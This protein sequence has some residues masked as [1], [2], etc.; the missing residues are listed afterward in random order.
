MAKLVLFKRLDEDP[1]VVDV[2]NESA[3]Q[4]ALRQLEAADVSYS[5]RSIRPIT[6]AQLVELLLK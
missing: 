5:H 2:G 1:I 3:W 4:E 6:P